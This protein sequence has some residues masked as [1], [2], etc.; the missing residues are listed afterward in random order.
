MSHPFMQELENIKTTDIDLFEAIVA[1]YKTIFNEGINDL[2]FVF[3]AD[4]IIQAI[5]DNIEYSRNRTRYELNILDEGFEYLSPN[6]FK[7]H[8]LNIRWV[9]NADYIGYYDTSINYI[10]IGFNHIYTKTPKNMSDIVKLTSNTLIHELRHWYDHITHGI[11]ARKFTRLSQIENPELKQAQLSTTSFANDK[12]I[13]ASTEINAH[14][15]DFIDGILWN[16]LNTNTKYTSK[17]LM[18]LFEKLVPLNGITKD[19][20]KRI[21]KRLYLFS[22][23]ILYLYTLKDKTTDELK[24][25]MIDYLKSYTGVMESLDY[26][27]SNIIKASNIPLFE[28]NYMFDTDYRTWFNAKYVKKGK[29]IQSTLNNVINH[30]NIFNT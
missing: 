24:S 14:I 22:Q 13:N 20:K 30:C 26:T 28:A 17:S 18:E 21:Y 4:D 12:Y 6:K 5:I 15:I 29:C 3:N 7:S 25:E 1:G 8:D 23:T 2:K 19:S 11:E 16:V 27:H 9:K 10:F